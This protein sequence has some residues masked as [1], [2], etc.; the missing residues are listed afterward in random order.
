M[1]KQ[2]VLKG[3]TFRDPGGNLDSRICYSIGWAQSNAAFQ[4]KRPYSH[5]EMPNDW[6]RAYEQGFRIVSATLSAGPSQGA[7]KKPYPDEPT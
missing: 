5:I 6:L 4:S 7:W 3:F 1:K 2:R